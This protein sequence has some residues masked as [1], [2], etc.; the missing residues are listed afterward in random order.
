M[1]TLVYMC[2]FYL[3]V[4]GEI[5]IAFWKWENARVAFLLFILYVCVFLV[6][7]CICYP[8][9]FYAACELWSEGYRFWYSVS[10][11]LAKMN[12]CG[13]H[14]FFFFIHFFERGQNKKPSKIGMLI[15][16]KIWMLCFPYCSA[17]YI[18]HIADLRSLMHVV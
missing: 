10:V 8:W 15:G 1:D 12:L 5:G 11:L 9:I 18:K 6:I 3:V 13:M 2:D 16:L 4:N 7:H 14:L 17:I